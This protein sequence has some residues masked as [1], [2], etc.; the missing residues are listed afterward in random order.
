MERLLAPHLFFSLPLHL[1]ALKGIVE[2]F[3]NLLTG[4]NRLLL[5]NRIDIFIGKP[6]PII[7]IGT[8]NKLTLILGGLILQ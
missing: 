1:P 4:N 7:L 3:H 5:V 8:A 6:S 2:G